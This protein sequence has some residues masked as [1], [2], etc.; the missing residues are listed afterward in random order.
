MVLLVVELVY[1]V[2]FWVGGFGVGGGGLVVVWVLLGVCLL[3]GVG[4]EEVFLGSG[5]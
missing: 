5:G 3:G 2:Y 4:G 1:F